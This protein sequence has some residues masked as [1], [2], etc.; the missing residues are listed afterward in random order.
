MTFTL[1]TATIALGAITP[2]T[3]GTDGA[4][5]MIVGT[6]AATGYTVSYAGTTLTSGVNTIAAM[7]GGS[8]YVAGTPGFGI[9]L[10]ANT[11]P[12]LGAAPSGGV[13]TAKPG[14]NTADQFKF[15]VAGD[16]IASSTGI[17]AN[18]TYTF[19]YAADISSATPAGQYSTVLTYT[20]T[21]NF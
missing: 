20:A 8:D 9:N 7:A 19:S 14:Y 11:T 10:A 6:N 21:A 5:T 15:S 2:A 17:S 13:G 12:A 3:S 1:A 4:H 18:T 16:Q